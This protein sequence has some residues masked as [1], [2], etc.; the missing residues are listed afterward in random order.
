M[1]GVQPWKVP[2]R[3]KI[4][5]ALGALADE[6]LALTDRTSTSGA[7]AGTILTFRCLSST[8]DKQYDVRLI[9]H[10]SSRNWQLAC[11]DNGSMFQGYVGY[12]AIAALC[13]QEDGL[14]A[15]GVDFGQILPIVKGVPW[16]DLAVRVKNDWLAV[17]QLVLKDFVKSD[18]N[19]TLLTKS[20]DALWEALRVMID[21][22]KRILR[23]EKKN[24]KRGR[25]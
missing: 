17:E 23:M 7:E 19:R 25:E 15:T 11:N 1:K 18:D 6:R 4:L 8:R 5:E 16:K 10:P 13:L 12:P 24:P 14:S 21:I 22:D 2:P 9:R 3:I 20:V